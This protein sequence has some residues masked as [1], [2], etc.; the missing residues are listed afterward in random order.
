MAVVTPLAAAVLQSATGMDIAAYSISRYDATYIP[1]GDGTGNRDVT[2]KL[3]I[4][5]DV[6][7]IPK[8]GVST[9]KFDC[10]D[11]VRAASVTD[12]KGRPVKCRVVKNIANADEVQWDS[13]WCWMGAQTIDVT[14]A[15]QADNCGWSGSGLQ[16]VDDYALRTDVPVRRARLTC[17]LPPGIPGEPTYTSPEGGRVERTL[18]GG[19][20]IVIDAQDPPPSTTVSFST[21]MRAQN[22]ERLARTAAENRAAWDARHPFSGSLAGLSSSLRHSR[23]QRKLTQSWFSCFSLCFSVVAAVSVFLSRRARTRSSPMQ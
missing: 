13:P 11:H 23:T 12:S 10:L 7:Y 19:S 8:A 5:Y 20:Q 22:N 18:D 6:G 16:I 2:T 1:V 21:G 15:W 9:V 14:I 17:V 4:T 3:R